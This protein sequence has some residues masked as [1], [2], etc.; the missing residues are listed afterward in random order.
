V[1][2]TANKVVYNTANKVVYNTCTANSSKFL[3]I[4]YLK[5]IIRTCRMSIETEMYFENCTLLGYCAASS[6]TLL[7]TFRD[8]LSV[9][10]SGFKSPKIG[11]LTPEER[12]DSWSL[13]MVLIGCPETSVRNYYSLRN[14]PEERN[15]HLLRGGS[16]R[17]RRNIFRPV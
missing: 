2:N 7:P 16:L 8:N 6:G 17:S 14:I 11:L 10:S 15:S 3:T 5:G 13:K 12:L 9:Q 1:Y 4:Q